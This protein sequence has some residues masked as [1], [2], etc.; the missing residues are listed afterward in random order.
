MLRLEEKWRSQL[1]TQSEGSKRTKVTSGGAYSSSSNR[2]TPLAEDA[3]IDSPV[4]PQGS[5][6]SKRRGKGKA[7]MFEDL[8]EAKSSVVKQLSLMEEFKI[9]REKE[10]LDEGE[11]REKLIAIRKK[12]LKIQQELKEQELE[13]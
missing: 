2:E 8:S 1:P 10:L 13:T 4:R 6:K 11:H 12:E 3:G 9:V 5:K 7:S